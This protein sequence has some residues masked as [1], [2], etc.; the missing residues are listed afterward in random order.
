MG[1]SFFVSAIG[2]D[3]GKTLISAILTQ[4]LEADYWKPVQSGEPRDT[5]MITKLLGKKVRTHPEAYLFSSPVSPHQAAKM[6]NQQIDLCKI[7]LPKTH[8]NLIIE[9]AGGVLV[10]LNERETILDL[11][12][13]LKVPLI[14]VSNYYL[15]SINHTLLT[16]DVLKQNNIK[17]EGIIFNGDQNEDSMRAILARTSIPHLYSIPKTDKIDPIFIQQHAHGIKSK[18]SKF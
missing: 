16:L 14:L 18:L 5:D 12:I 11:I 7:S 4:A 2:T 8:N 6:E 10:P 3:S 15:G 17:V 1:K 9:G 13:H